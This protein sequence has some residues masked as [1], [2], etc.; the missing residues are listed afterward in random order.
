MLSVCTDGSLTV[1][2]HMKKVG[3]FSSEPTKPHLLLSWQEWRKVEDGVT[4]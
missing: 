3:K 1:V 2:T 4:G